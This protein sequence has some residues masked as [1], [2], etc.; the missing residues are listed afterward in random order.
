MCEFVFTEDIRNFNVLARR[1]LRC[2]RMCKIHAECIV[3]VWPMGIGPVGTLCWCERAIINYIRTIGKANP[4]SQTKTRVATKFFT[5]CTPCTSRKLIQWN[6]FSSI[7]E[8]WDDV[9]CTFS[10][11]IA[12]MCRKPYRV[13]ASLKP[14]CVPAAVVR[15]LLL[16]FLETGQLF[17][18]IRINRRMKCFF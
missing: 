11:R 13:Y 5:M 18:R 2:P 15:M 6:I 1:L 3:P 14:C 10:R 12:A 16:L 7:W 8:L 4:A 9:A 17:D